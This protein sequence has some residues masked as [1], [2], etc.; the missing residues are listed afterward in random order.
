MFY[1]YPSLIVLAS[2][3]V[4]GTRLTPRLLAVV[5]V[6]LIGV[7]LVVGPGFD[8]L[9]WRG[10]A[11]ALAASAATATQFFAA[12]RC[13]QDRVV[14]KVFWVHLLVLPDGAARRSVTASWHRPRRW[15]SHLSRSR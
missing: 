7:V 9:D 2:P 13:P 1:A 5:C 6:A 8:E 10:L 4:D 15:R 3:F 11:L 12:S 14:A